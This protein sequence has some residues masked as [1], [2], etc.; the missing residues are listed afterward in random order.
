MQALAAVAPKLKHKPSEEKMMIRRVV[1]LAAIM[2]V[3]AHAAAE[4]VGAAAKGGHP[5][6][7]F[8]EKTPR[9]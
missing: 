7:L 6:Y 4:T 3:T 8:L 2:L 9:A 5:E 1:T